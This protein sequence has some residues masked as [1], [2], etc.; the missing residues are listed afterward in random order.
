MEETLLLNKKQSSSLAT[1][2]ALLQGVGLGARKLKER[3]E[4][5][6]LFPVY[7]LSV[8]VRIKADKFESDKRR[9]ETKVASFAGEETLKVRL[10]SL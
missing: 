1:E 6:N 8:S 4:K 3:E 5:G 2:S 7:T 10:K 9:I